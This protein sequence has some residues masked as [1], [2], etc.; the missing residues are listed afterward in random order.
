MSVRNCAFPWTSAQI[1]VSGDVMPCGHGS[2]PVGNL[3]EHSFAEIW[4]G[5][6]LQ[7]VRASILAGEVH[8]VCQC[9][10]CPFQ[11]PQ[12]A[13]PVRQAP[14]EGTERLA[15]RFDEAW[16][17]REHPDVAGALQR[18]Q[19]VSGLEHFVLH[20]KSEGRAHRLHLP[21]W[22]SRIRA[23]LGFGPP[24]AP[25]PNHIRALVEHAQGKLRLQ[26]MP[27]D[28]TI[29][30]TNL[31]NL[32]CVMCPQGMGRV[33]KMEHTSMDIIRRALP[34]IG[35]ASRLIISGIGE[36]MVSPGFWAVMDE[37]P[38]RDD[39]LVRM[40]S[41]GHFIN[42]ERARRIVSSPLKWLLISIDAA[43]PETYGRI[44]GGDFALV[45]QNI[46]RLVA[47]RRGTP[48]SHLKISLT[49]TLM[50][51]NLAEA[52]AFVQLGKDLGVDTVIFS[53][54]FELGNEPDWIVARGDWK[55]VY[56]EQMISARRPEVSARMRAALTEGK[57]IGM[58]VHFHD[59]V[60][61]YIEDFTPAGDLMN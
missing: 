52:E 37:T 11:Q 31:C 20:G 40:H 32:R 35:T 4:N 24:P 30:V 36:A 53:Q 7:A 58:P 55:F 39:L 47:T 48:G 23:L 44:R 9:K 51:E 33:K 26:A 3:R 13:F 56:S 43:T 49:M 41:N 28:L 29:V 59:D 18:G 27:V 8:P 16:Y 57:R 61:S 42:D 6:L 1:T 60:E 34:C 14:L 12:V 54:L 17:R 10:L 2:K 38:P 5:P 15:T 25:F 22:L 45:C 19:F 50:G 46:R 21:S